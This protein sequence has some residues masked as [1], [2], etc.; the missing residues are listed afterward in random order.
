MFFQVVFLDE[1]EVEYISST[2]K[3]DSNL[4]NN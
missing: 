4:S 3:H 1:G 2:F